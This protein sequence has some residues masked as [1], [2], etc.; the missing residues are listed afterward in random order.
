Y[1]SGVWSFLPP[2]ALWII[3]MYSAIKVDKVKK[4]ENIRTYKEIIAFMKNQD[5]DAVRNKRNKTKDFGI[6]SLIVVGFGLVSALL[7]LV[8]VYLFQG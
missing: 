2:L 7:A 4:K 1:L 8:S 5:L 6:L 3:G